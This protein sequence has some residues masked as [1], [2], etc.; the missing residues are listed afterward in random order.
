VL[1]T[2][3]HN[4]WDS[5]YKYFKQ[6]TR[7]IQ[8]SVLKELSQYHVTNRESL[9]QHTPFRTEKKYVSHKYS[10][11]LRETLFASELSYF[12]TQASSPTQILPC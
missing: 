12:I 8:K 7:Y 10:Q 6:V 4:F 5:T 9:L 3:T 1:V 11:H 2:L